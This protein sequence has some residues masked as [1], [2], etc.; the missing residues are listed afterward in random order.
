[1]K[2]YKNTSIHKKN[3]DITYREVIYTYNEREE[4]E[5]TYIV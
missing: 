3:N 5:Y 2:Q 1:M 4:I